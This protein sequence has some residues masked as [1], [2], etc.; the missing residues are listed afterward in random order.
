MEHAKNK[1]LI[2]N[3]TL[4]NKQL[5][6]VML[7]MALFEFPCLNMSKYTEQMDRA[8]LQDA[9]CEENTKQDV[10]T[11]TSPSSDGTDCG[12]KTK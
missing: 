6:V 5:V 12:M 8:E 3:G 2:S 9:M 1:T 10:T 11:P 7:V 4:S